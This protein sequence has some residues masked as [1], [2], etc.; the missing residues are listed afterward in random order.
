MDW[1][2]NVQTFNLGLKGKKRFPIGIQ[3]HQIKLIFV[4]AKSII[5]T[6]VNWG[7][8]SF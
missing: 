2:N 4:I 5:E 7:P 1:F 8:G 3:T 6:F